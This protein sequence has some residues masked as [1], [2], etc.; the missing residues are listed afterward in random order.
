MAYIIEWYCFSS[1]KWILYSV[2]NPMVFDD[3]IEAEQIMKD[4]TKS[5]NPK[6][7]TG[8]NPDFVRIK[9]KEAK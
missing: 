6:K 1:N 2:K 8:W 4:L 7:M 9:Y 3:I 5:Y